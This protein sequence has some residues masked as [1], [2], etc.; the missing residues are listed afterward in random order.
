[1]RRFVALEGRPGEIVELAKKSQQK[2]ELPKGSYE[3][4]AAVTKRLKFCPKPFIM[5]IIRLC[6]W[7]KRRDGSQTLVWR[8]V[9]YELRIQ[10]F[11]FK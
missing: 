11:I 3:S 10:M 8:G 4:G 2:D 6:V 5:S 7:L 1:M 9:I